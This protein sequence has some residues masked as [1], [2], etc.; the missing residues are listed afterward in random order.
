[1]SILRDPRAW[2][3]DSTLIN[4]TRQHRGNDLKLSL[5][6]RLRQ[7]L[8]HNS[9][10]YICCS[11]RWSPYQSC[12][13]KQ[14]VVSGKMTT[15]EKVNTYR[16]LFV[17]TN[18]SSKPDVHFQNECQTV[19]L[20]SLTAFQ[21][22]PLTFQIYSLM[23]IATAQVNDCLCLLQPPKVHNEITENLGGDVLPE[24]LQRGFDKCKWMASFILWYQ[25]FLLHLYFGA[26]WLVGSKL[27]HCQVHQRL[28]GVNQHKSLIVFT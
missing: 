9:D 28:P 22:A 12:K 8:K 23:F 2:R 21:T 26:D 13:E 20:C 25:G 16:T 11:Q 24:A 4:W 7:Q 18:I 27:W 5:L 14:S 1:M 6:K 10:L 15:A 17:L 3:C 19:A